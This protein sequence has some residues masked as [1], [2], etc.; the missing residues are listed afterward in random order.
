MREHSRKVGVRVRRKRVNVWC[1]N[2]MSLKVTGV[3][4]ERCL[5]GKTNTSKKGVCSLFHALRVL[6]CKEKWLCFQLRVSASRMNG[7]QVKED[8]APGVSC[9]AIS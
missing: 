9:V 1:P 5:V 2:T 6:E 8:V 7:E 3:F 4:E